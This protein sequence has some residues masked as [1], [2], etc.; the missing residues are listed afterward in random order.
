MLRF[1][2]AHVSKRAPAAFLTSPR[3][4][5]SP[6]RR[7]RKTRTSNTTECV[8]LTL[9]EAVRRLA[10][11]AVCAGLAACAA[12][13]PPPCAAGNLSAHQ[14]ADA[15]TFAS[16]L[17]RPWPAGSGSSLLAVSS[18]LTERVSIYDNALL[19]LYLMRRGE[20]ARA[21]SVL[22]AL[23]QL[24]RED[25]SL[26]FTFSWPAPD[27]H[28]IY[29]RSGAIAWVGY[30]AVEYLNAERGGPERERITALA[31]RA[32]RYL[33]G[34][35]ASE[36]DALT[37]LVLGGFG[38]F[39]IDAAD[40]GV[41]ER[42]VPGPITWASTEHNVDSYFFLRDLALLTENAEYA[43]AAERIRAA[44][45]TRGWLPAAGQ[46]ARGFQ[47]GGV[48]A[49]FALDCASWGAL[50][51]LAS[52]ERLRAETS[53][54]AAEAR[55]AASSGAARGHRPYAHAPLIENRALAEKLRPR[56]PALE[57]DELEAVWPEGSAGVALAALRLGQRARAAA[58]LDALEPLRTQGGGMPTFTVEIPSEMDTAPSLAGTLW[59]ELVR[60][61]L[62]RGADQPVMWRP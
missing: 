33:I 2:C 54:G 3:P 59:I 26:P 49:A 23:A 38:N 36:P 34:L 15:Y 40:G 45:L 29:L 57:W 37:G 8:T 1:A 52:Q 12:S 18:A 43:A 61:E 47:T 21:A 7:S 62:N 31:H 32:A 16:Q 48:D 51:L 4:S 55:Y 9:V 17:M 14:T 46:L 35:Q 24:Q 58:I 22:L 27:P 42:Y 50:F 41:R 6:N 20:R 19:S 39:V 60:Y 44:L 28:A 5:P 11:Q 30:A 56:L 10:L 53:L 25:G 13:T